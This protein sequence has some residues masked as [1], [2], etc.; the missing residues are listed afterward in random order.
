VRV[1]SQA[2][3]VTAFFLHYHR[4]IEELISSL[5]DLFVFVG[6]AILFRPP[7]RKG[8]FRSSHTN[9]LTTPAAV[10]ESEK[11]IEMNE[12]VTLLDKGTE[13]EVYCSTSAKTTTNPF[14]PVMLLLHTPTSTVPQ[15]LPPRPH[16]SLA[17][18]EQ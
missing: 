1:L 9:Q 5:W 2:A 7:Q 18:R 15:R 10:E 13:N 3:V 8:K 11:E 14:M 4:W 17:W 12:I 16:F 6:I